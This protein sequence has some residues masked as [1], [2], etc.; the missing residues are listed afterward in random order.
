VCK[1]RAVKSKGKPQNPGKG[2]ANGKDAL[3]QKDD[4]LIVAIGAS[5]GGIEAFTD[6]LRNLPTNTGMAFVIVQHLDPKHQSFLTELLSKGARRRESKWPSG[7]T[8]YK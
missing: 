1:D 3:R 5:A 7:Q 8:K 2:S 6:L 4:L